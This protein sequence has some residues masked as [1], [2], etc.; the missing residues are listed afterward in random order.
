[1]DYS[2]ETLV[3]L[4]VD[5]VAFDEIFIQRGCFFSRQVCCCVS[6]SQ[7]HIQNRRPVWFRH[8]QFWA[9]VHH[10]PVNSAS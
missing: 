7:L 8:N 1:M 10:Q 5:R 9:Y 4:G 3:K 6:S 2:A